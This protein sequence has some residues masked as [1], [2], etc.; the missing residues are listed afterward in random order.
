MWCDQKTESSL[1][2]TAT[3][4]LP[5]HH[6]DASTDILKIIKMA[7]VIFNIQYISERLS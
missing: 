7:H 5:Y 3:P 6:S 2:R 1:I 4:S